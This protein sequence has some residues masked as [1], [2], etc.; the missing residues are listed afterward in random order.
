MSGA[1]IL[2]IA[3]PTYNR[4]RYLGMALDS[5]R[6]ALNELD[7]TGRAAVD[8][9][10]SDNCSPDDTPAVVARHLDLPARRVTAVRNDSNVGPDRNVRQCYR[11][12]ETPYVWILGDDDVILPG[13]IAKV[14]AAL[15]DGTADIVYAESYGYS[16]DHKRT[17]L[18]RFTRGKT[19]E[20]R[21]ALD[22]ARRTHVKLTYLS[23]VIVKTGVDLTPY[24]GVLD[25][26]FLGQ[27]G[28][29]LQLLA[30]GRKFVVID[31]WI[32]AGK[33]DNS[34]GYNVVKVFAANLARITQTILHSAPALAAAIEN[35][36]IVAFFPR[37]I[38]QSRRAKADSEERSAIGAELAKAFG[39]NWRRRVF[40]APLLV[41]PL[42]LAKAYRVLLA[43]TQRL[44]GR[45]LI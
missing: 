38:V 5:I 21:N 18:H 41:L 42:P 16:D 8:I 12:A 28:W 15:A 2:T 39:N 27:F 32:V 23:A 10:I 3:I 26:S 40:L 7:E 37:I 4:S 22:F 43:L 35:G 33:I 14:L 17:P 6:A 13:G 30:G 24:L 19:I 34:G 25:D 29:V 20:Y 44:L 45:F 31:D 36:A 11:S 1:P 9:F